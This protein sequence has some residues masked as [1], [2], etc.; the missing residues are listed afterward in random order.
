VHLHITASFNRREVRTMTSWDYYPYC[1]GLAADAS[2]SLKR[3]RCQSPTL[4][5]QSSPFR[6]ASRLPKRNT[7]FPFPFLPPLLPSFPFLLPLALYT[8]T[9]STIKPPPRGSRTLSLLHAFLIR[10]NN[11]IFY[12][13]VHLCNGMHISFPYADPIFPLPPSYRDRSYSECI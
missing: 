5:F 6:R 3:S 8:R 9:T 1:T 2:V 12:S 7:P 11:S 4:P 10:T 13:L